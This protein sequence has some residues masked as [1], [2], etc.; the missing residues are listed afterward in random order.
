MYKLGAIKSPPDERDYQFSTYNTMHEV[1]ARFERPVVKLK[2]QGRLGSCVGF[3]GSY[4]KD[5]QEKRNYPLKIPIT[6]PLYIYKKCK[7]RDGIP[8]AE[9]TYIRT[10]NDVLKNVG[11][12]LEKTYQYSDEKPMRPIPPEADKEA[13]EYK[14][15]HYVRLNNLHEIKQAIVEHGYVVAGFMVLSTFMEPELDGVNA[16]VPPFEG[17]ILGGHAVS[18]IGYDD[19]LTHTYRN[20]N[21]FTGFIKIVN[22]WRDG[23]GKWWGSGGT[24]Y[25]PYDLLYADIAKDMPGMIPLM[26]A[27]AWQDEVKP[28]EEVKHVNLK[29]GSD[30]VSVDGEQITI[31]QPP[32]ID[33][34]SNRTLVPLKFVS[35]I[36]GFDVVW[37]GEKREIDI[38]RRG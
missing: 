28:V 35:D 11:T 37:N 20:G 15:K 5:E 36:L 7:E 3:A 21:S 24:A 14:I 13:E 1:P 22:S 19:D 18:V 33:R 32:V 34:D 10:A 12:C 23:T 30:V 29:I 4:C 17:H 31:D 25:I 2:D 16:F 38:Y 8:D 26:E 9:G 6:S 27:W